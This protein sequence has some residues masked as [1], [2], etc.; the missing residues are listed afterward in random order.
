MSGRRCCARPRPA[1]VSRS[2]AEYGS[3]SEG[4]L[5]LSGNGKY[6]TIMGYGVN[7]AAFD[8]DPAEVRRRP[9]NALGQ[10]GS[11]D[12]TELHRRA[13]RRRP[14]RRQRRGGHH[15]R[16]LQHLQR[17]QTRPAVYT[18]DGSSFY[19][20][21]QGTSPD[22][23]SG[24]YYA[25]KGATRR[26]GDHRQRHQRRRLVAGYP[27]RPGLQR[28]ALCLGRQ[29]GRQRFRTA[30]SSARWARPAPCRRPWP[31]WARAL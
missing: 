2:R 7:A 19:T 3:S 8:A 15:D 31:P 1:P 24:V 18:V 5:Q 28:P 6:L 27:R 26:D 22:H 11:L 14:D 16:A 23:T 4:T 25:A 10:S 20:S 30:T 29:Q 9:S 13:P 17:Q 12:R 21:G